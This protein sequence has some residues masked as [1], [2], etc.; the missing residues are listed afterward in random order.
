MGA[1]GVELG[2]ALAGAAPEQED[3]DPAALFALETDRRR[4]PR[5]L[6]T[7]TQAGGSRLGLS[8]V[9]LGRCAHV[10]A[11]HSTIFG[12]SSACALRPT[13]GPTCCSATPTSPS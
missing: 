8:Y 13:R 7:Y 3:L 11:V 5:D 4:A 2:L 6:H 1:P 12:H 9:N 10:L